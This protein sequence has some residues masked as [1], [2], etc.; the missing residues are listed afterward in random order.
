MTALIAKLLPILLVDVVNP[1]LFGTL[2]YCAGSRHPLAN[3]LS[4]LA[5]HTAAYVAGGIVVALGVEQIADRLLN[6][7]RIDFVISGL[8]GVALV[9][10]SIPAKKKGTPQAREPDWELT[11]LK[12][13][14]FGA[15]LN[16][17]GLPFALPYF[18]AIDMIVG[19]DL[20]AIETLALIAA[21][22]L[23]YALPFLAIPVTVAIFGDRSRPLLEKTKALLD[24]V[25]GVLMPLLLFVIGAALIADSV[26]FFFRGSGLL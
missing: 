7:E 8:I 14:G 16:F 4:L 5:G 20:T 17:V 24:R 25:A 23:A 12:C 11:P 22:N 18:A 15:I 10:V 1:V 21:Y 9:V 3:G 19:A 26:A 2:V 6:P 13:F